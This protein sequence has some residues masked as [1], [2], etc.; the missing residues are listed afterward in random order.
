MALNILILCGVAAFVVLGLRSSTPES[1]KVL[2]AAAS[3]KDDKQ[4]DPLDQISSADIAVNVARM[5]GLQE[6]RKV[7]EDA[8]SVDV[9]LSLPP[10][11]ASIAAKPAVVTTTLKSRKD[12]QQYTTVAGDTVTTLATKFGVTSDSI[13]WSNNLASNIIPA[14]QKLYIPPQNGLVYVVAAGDTADSLANKFKA[15]KDE[16]VAANDAELKPLAAGER[17]LI[18]GGIQPA[19]V[20]NTRVSTAGAGFGWGGP[21]YGDNLYTFGYCTWY[22]ARR[23]IVPNNWGNANTWDTRAAASGWIVSSIPRVGAIAQTDRG[24]EGHVAYVE[25]V[26]EDGTQIKYSDMNGLAGWGTAGRSWETGAYAANGGW[27]PASKFE[28]YIYQ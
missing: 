22:V 6:S 27:A 9:E 24:S 4:A 17:V 8:D 15:S 16:I 18:P 5:S 21:S 28:H 25:A 7:A 12:I 19:P 23:V 10:A 14:G 20:V 2:A 1:Q 26:S 3:T 13:R 11:S